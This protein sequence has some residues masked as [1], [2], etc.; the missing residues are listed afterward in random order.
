M[1]QSIYSLAVARAFTTAAE[2]GHKM[3]KLDVARCAA[4]ARCELCGNSLTVFFHTPVALMGTALDKECDHGERNAAP[5]AAPKPPTGMA[6]ALPRSPLPVPRKGQ[7]VTLS[8][9]QLDDIPFP[10]DAPVRDCVVRR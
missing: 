4:R 10:T 9:P 2:L 8:V 1:G 7:P 5:A 6:K 3:S